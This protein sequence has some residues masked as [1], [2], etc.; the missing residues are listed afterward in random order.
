MRC[1]VCRGYSVIVIT[2]EGRKDCIR[3]RR[4]CLD[5]GRRFWTREIP[6]EIADSKEK[7]K[8]LDKGRRR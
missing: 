4:L 1:P 6:V 5:C 8:G 7:S 2:T 3:R